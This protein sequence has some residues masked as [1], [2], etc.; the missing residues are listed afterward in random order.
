VTSRKYLSLLSWSLHA[1]C[2]TC[3]LNYEEIPSAIYDRL[4]SVFHISFKALVK[5][6]KAESLI[7]MLMFKI[8][9]M[10]NKPS[11]KKD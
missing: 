7:V 10:K 4:F 6:E 11:M 9:G 8:C 1:G 5:A 3:L 2:E